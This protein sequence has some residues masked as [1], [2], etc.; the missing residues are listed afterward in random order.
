MILQRLVVS[1]SLEVTVIFL[2]VALYAV[3]GYVTYLGIFAPIVVVA[4]QRPLTSLEKLL[5]V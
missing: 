3:L 2:N 5:G 1:R 4:T